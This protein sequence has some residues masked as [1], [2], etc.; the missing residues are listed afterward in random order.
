MSRT[1]LVHM[2]LKIIKKNAKLTLWFIQILHCFDL[3][4]YNIEETKDFLQQ[5]EVDEELPT[6]YITKESLGKIPIGFIQIK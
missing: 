5:V 1:Y 2:I 6:K 4:D 3:F